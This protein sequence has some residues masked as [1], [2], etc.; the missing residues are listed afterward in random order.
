M[1]FKAKMEVYAVQKVDGSDPAIN[2][3][4][5]P[6]TR[7][8]TEENKTFSKYTP[9]GNITLYVTNPNLFGIQQGDVYL[10]DFTKV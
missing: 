8:D 1:N 5:H 7:E 3:I 6:I 2:V 10:V 9:S 4:M